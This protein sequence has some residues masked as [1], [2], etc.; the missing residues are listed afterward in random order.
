MRFT[1]D[2][3]FHIG[4]QHL[5]GGVPCQDYAMSGTTE[6]YGFA[7]ISDGCSTG[8]ETDIGARIVARSTRQALAWAAPT[9]FSEERVDTYC[10]SADGFAQGA[11]GLTQSDMLATCG[12]V[13]TLRNHLAVRLIGDG[14]IAAKKKNGDLIATRVDWADNT[15]LYRAYADDHFERFIAAHGGRDAMAM[16]VTRHIRRGD[17][18][19]DKVIPQ[20]LYE[21]L[22]GFGD[23]MSLRDFEFV[24]VFSDG[25]TQVDGVDWRDA[26]AELM[27][28]KSSE[29]AFVK[30]RMLRFLKD[31]QAHGKGPVDDI[32]MA[33]IHINHEA[34]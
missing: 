34:A 1:A 4:T 26:V 9:F 14:V 31:C 7:I 5:R 24:A 2:H 22:R 12:Y 6:D 11:L 20:A 15:P 13:A 3:A 27:A 10:R 32:S 8:G 25:V 28:F 19:D 18:R 33:C 17:A 30:R 16:T 23:A 29:G 21:S